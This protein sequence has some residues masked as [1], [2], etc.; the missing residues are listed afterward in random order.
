MTNPVPLMKPNN[1]FNGRDSLA[2]PGGNQMPNY[3]RMQQQYDFT[4]S[5]SNAENAKKPKLDSN[6]SQFRDGNSATQAGI[7]FALMHT[8]RMVLLEH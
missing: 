2:L 1:M 7:L 3:Q 4:D 6:D 8:S 5:L